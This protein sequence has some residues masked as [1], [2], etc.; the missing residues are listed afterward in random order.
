VAFY[1]L[2]LSGL[3]DVLYDWLDGHKIPAS[4][5]SLNNDPSILLKPAGGWSLAASAL[6]WVAF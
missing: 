3:E 6:I 1:T 5:P 2:T 4:C